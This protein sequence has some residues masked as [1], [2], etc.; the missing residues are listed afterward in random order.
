M[1]KTVMVNHRWERLLN[2]KVGPNPFFLLEV[3]DL[4]RVEARD[5]FC[6]QVAHVDNI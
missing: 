3:G 6:G 2:V 5:V 1:V 4:T